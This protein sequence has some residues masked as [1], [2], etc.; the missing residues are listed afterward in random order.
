MNSVSVSVC[1]LLYINNVP[2]GWKVYT[3][4]GKTRIRTLGF[5][6][7]NFDNILIRLTLEPF[8]ETIVGTTETPQQ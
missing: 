1:V 5:V 2:V 8:L 7:K 3:R 6:S 4:S